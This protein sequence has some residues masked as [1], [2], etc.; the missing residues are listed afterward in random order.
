MGVIEVFFV[1]A[2]WFVLSLTGALAPGPLSA[3]VIQQASKHGRLHG[4]LPMVGH[5]LV[6]L[7][8]I[9]AIILGVNSAFLDPYTDFLMGFGG[10]IIILFGIL[11]L[12]DY[13]QES[14]KPTA[15]LKHEMTATSALEATTQ[16]AL[17]SI[18][19]PYFLLWWIAAGFTAITYLLE[20]VQWSVGAVLVAGT[21]IYFTHIS[22][23]FI[24]GAFLSVG[25]TYGSKKA[26]VD[27]KVGRL[28]LVNIGIGFF[29]IVLG[30]FFVFLAL[31]GLF[32]G[33]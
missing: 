2:G 23:D 14:T 33:S 3:A 1:L 6:E 24:F 32:F 21:L 15:E 11:A 7:V 8:I 30:L 27:S 26:Q 4:I 28:N 29:Q 16:G 20:N 25:A 18:F 17:V 10:V 12:R 9:A 22:T 31:P 5:A 19:S 13:K